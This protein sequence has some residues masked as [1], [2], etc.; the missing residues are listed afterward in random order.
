MVKKETTTYRNYTGHEACLF[1]QDGEG[2]GQD[3]LRFPKSWY[4]IESRFPL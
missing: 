2:E 1:S 3:L 4:V